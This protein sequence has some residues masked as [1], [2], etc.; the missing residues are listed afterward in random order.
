MGQHSEQCGS[1]PS[2]QMETTQKVNGTAFPRDHQNAEYEAA[3]N[4]VLQEK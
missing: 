1:K 2:F 3:Y 4:Y